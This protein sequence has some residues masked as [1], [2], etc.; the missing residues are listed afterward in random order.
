VRYAQEYGGQKLHLVRE[1]DPAF[2]RG[3]EVEM[4]ALCGRRPS[5]RGDWR[6]TINVP[7]G[8]A[9]KGCLRVWRSLV[10]REVTPCQP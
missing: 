1:V 2:N 5:K 4:V 6:M 9:C 7:L 3:R 10:A 8:H